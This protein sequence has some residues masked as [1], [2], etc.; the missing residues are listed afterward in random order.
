MFKLR[1]ADAEQKPLYLRIWRELSKRLRDDST[2]KVK[3]KLKLLHPSVVEDV[4]VEQRKHHQRKSHQ[5]P[6]NHSPQRNHK[7][8]PREAVAAEEK[9]HRLR[10]LMSEAVNLVGKRL[11]E[12]P[13]DHVRFDRRGKNFERRENSDHE[14]NQRNRDSPAESASKSVFH[15]N[16]ESRR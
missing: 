16:R 3:A 13:A 15:V 10:D 9:S 11:V 7:S 1:H 2:N 8:A 6:E 5:R 14:P 12:E 4:E